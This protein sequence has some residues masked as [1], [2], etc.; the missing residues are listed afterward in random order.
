MRLIDGQAMQSST[1][2]N[3]KGLNSSFLTSQLD[4]KKGLIY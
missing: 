2:A 4:H 1:I 3:I